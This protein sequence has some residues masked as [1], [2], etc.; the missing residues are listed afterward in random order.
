MA[1]SSSSKKTRAIALRS[2]LSPFGNQL[3]QKGFIDGDKMQKALAESRKTGRSLVDILESDTGKQLPPDL[4]HQYKKH[5]LFEL[6]ILYGVE[7]VDPELETDKF[8]DNQMEEL[9][10]SLIPLDICRR[11]R[12]IPLKKEEGD[13]PAL[14][15][16]MVRS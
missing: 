5:H 13:K 11:Y 14:L 16:A 6:K 3:V 2:N 1:Y 9:I 10:N 12:L 8:A 7:S 15:V 4:L